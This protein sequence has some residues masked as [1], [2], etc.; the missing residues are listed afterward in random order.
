MRQTNSNATP[1]GP[2]DA[3]EYT[4]QMSVLEMILATSLLVGT[5]GTKTVEMLDIKPPTGSAIVFRFPSTCRRRQAQ[6]PFLLP[7]EQL[8]GIRRYLS[9]SVSDLAKVLRVERPTVYSWLKG[10]AIPRSGN[11]N[12]IGAIYSIAREWRL[13]SSEPIRGMLNTPYGDDTTLLG[14]L[15]E[16]TVDE[17]A[18]RRLLGKLREALDRVPP[19]KSVAEIAKERGIRLPVRELSLDDQQSDI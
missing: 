10:E 14:L 2:L 12:R 9:L 6:A 13:M 11:V 5:G 18:T 7:Q 19:R 17:V 1:L 16:E 3:A 8:A 4:N 15:S